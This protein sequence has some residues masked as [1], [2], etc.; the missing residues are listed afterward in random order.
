M[1]PKDLDRGQK[2]AIATG[3]TALVVLLGFTL[4]FMIRYPAV[5]AAVADISIIVL[6]LTVIVLDIILIVL[7]WQ[8]V[9]LLTYLLE[10]LQPIVESLQETTGTVRGTAT[11][12]SDAVVNPTIEIASRAAGVR[13]SISI[14]AGSVNDLRPKQRGGQR[15][16]GDGTS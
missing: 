11:F 4:F 6:A 12:M 15:S 16:P 9:K 2:I 7:V 8:I 13:R 3:V 1:F 10:E 5:T 14:L